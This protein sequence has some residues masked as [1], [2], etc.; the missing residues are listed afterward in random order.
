MVVE[1]CGLSFL[2]GLW[3]WTLDIICLVWSTNLQVWDCRFAYDVPCCMRVCMF[4]CLSIGAYGTYI[5]LLNSRCLE[6][7]KVCILACI[8]IYVT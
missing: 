8:Y 2:F 4:V 6:L 7:C 1:L 5:K 3:V